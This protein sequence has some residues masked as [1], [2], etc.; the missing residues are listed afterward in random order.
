MAWREAD[1]ASL[2]WKRHFL[3]HAHRPPRPGRER[4]GENLTTMEKAAEKTLSTQGV[5]A[6]DKCKGQSHTEG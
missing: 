4:G 3:G 2:A 5:K 6:I 1:R